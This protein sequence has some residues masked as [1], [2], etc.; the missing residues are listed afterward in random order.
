MY[1]FCT[2]VI[3]SKHAEA[4]KLLAKLTMVAIV[5]PQLACDEF[6]LTCHFARVTYYLDV[7]TDSLQFFC[8]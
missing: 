1:I 3:A 4:L 8:C 5:I 2:S 6:L 7:S